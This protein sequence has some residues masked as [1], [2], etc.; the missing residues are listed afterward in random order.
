MKQRFFHRVFWYSSILSCT[1]FSAPNLFTQNA[2]PDPLENKI[3]TLLANDNIREADSLCT[4]FDLTRFMGP[5]DLVKW[6]RIKG[7]LGQYGQ[8]GRLACLATG[9]DPHFGPML[10]YQLAEVVKD[11]KIDTVRAVLQAY[12][13]CALGEG[14]CDTMAFK[15]WISG[16][17]DRFGL[18]DEEVDALVSLDSKN[19]PSAQELL[20]AA[21]QRFS[22]GL[23]SRAIRPALLAYARST[24]VSQKTLCALLLYQS[25]AQTEKNDSAALWLAKVPLSQDSYKAEAITFFQRSRYFAKADSLIKT[26]RPSFMRDTLAIRQ[27]L[28]DGNV[29]GATDAAAQ[30][31]QAQSRDKSN[32]NEAMLWRIRTL[33]FGG[34]I[35]AV[36]PLPDSINF[37]PSMNGAEEVLSDKYAFI[38]LQAYPS[39]WKDFGSIRLAAWAQ[40]P[41][42]ALRALGSPELENCPAGVKD[43]LI[44]DGVKT[45]EAGKLFSEARAVLE[46]TAPAA[47]SAEHRY[48]Y[49]EALL[50]AG[51]PEQARQALE[52]LVL[53][54]PGDVFSEKARIALLRLQNKI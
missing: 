10:Q 15:Q 4:A 1:A 49:A 35:G 13:L 20:E 50:G 19:H 16:T 51:A 53:K 31:F 12:V 5:F 38:M 18:Y 24:T 28:Y 7:T 21:R 54:F 36:L 3:S 52:E 40:R 48:Y 9:K 6:L 44:I 27:M 46:R 22:R 37:T 47:A 14:K 17:Y 34:F 23:F 11:A 45:L 25:Y 2:A 39:I 32:R 8:A 41:D 42:I 30:A 43:L 33:I 26:L 29:K